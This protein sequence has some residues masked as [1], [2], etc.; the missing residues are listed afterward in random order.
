MFFVR[1]YVCFVRV[2]NSKIAIN[3]IVLGVNCVVQQGNR[4]CGHAFVLGD[5]EGRG[6]EG[7]G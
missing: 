1:L 2:R 5:D 6:R 7:E 3:H 4:D